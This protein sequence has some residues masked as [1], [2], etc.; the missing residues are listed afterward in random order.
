VSIDCPL[1]G[2]HQVEN[3][4]SAAIALDLLGVDPGGI[5]ETVWPGRLELVR[6]SP[7][8][9]LDGAHNPA[10]ARALAA[11][12]ERFYRGRVV[13]LVFATMRDKPVAEMAGILFPMASRVILTAPDN[14][15][16]LAA[17]ELRGYAP[18]GSVIAGT[19]AEAVELA[20]AAPPETAVFF[21]GSLF[22]AG[23]ARA[24][25]KLQ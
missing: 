9:V 5:A 13:W 19:V 8:I 16:A 21:A 22:L 4:L 20:L 18:E 17:A 3:A 10:G 1:A 11:Y 6:R 14:S 12:V 15:R 24:L 25:L 7:D 23:E 2:E